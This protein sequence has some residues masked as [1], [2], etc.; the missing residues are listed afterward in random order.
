MRMIARFLAAALVAA[1]IGGSACAVPIRLKAGSF[2]PPPK[3]QARQSVQTSGRAGHYVVQ[4]AGPIRD[5]WKL[6]AAALGVKLQDYIPDYAFVAKMTPQQASSLLD[7]DCVTWVGPLTSDHK[8]DARLRI[9]SRNRLDLM[10]RLATPESAA[11]VESWIRSRNGIVDQ[12]YR[13]SSTYLIASLPAK[14]LD[15]LSSLQ[16]V[17]W[18]EEWQKPKLANNVAQ[19][20]VGAPDLRLRS[21]LYGAGQIIAFADSGLDTGNLANLSADFSGRLVSAYSLR[22]ANDWS[23][24]MSH[25]THVMG[26]AVG[27]GQLSGSNPP[28]H[29]YTGS[30]AGVA[31][32]AGYVIQSIGDESAFVYP[33]LDLAQLFQ[34]AYDDGARIHSDSWGSPSAGQYTVYSRQVDDF[35][36]HHPDMVLVFPAGN[37]GRDGN[38]DGVTDLGSVY[39]P[40]TAK[41]C[42]TVGATESLRDTGRV[43][44]YGGQWGSDF[45]AA[46]IRDDYISNNASGMVGWS[47][48]GPCQDGRT[49]PD[50]CAPATN[51]VSAKSHAPGA[52]PDWW[53]NY[54]ANYVYWGGTSMSTPLVAGAAALVRE[55]YSTDWGVE[56]SAALVKATL[57]NGAY[58]ITPGQYGSPYQQEVPARPNNVEGWGRLNLAALDPPAPRVVEFIDETAGLETRETRQYDVTVLGGSS[59][60]R[61]TLVWSDPPG[62]PLASLQLVNDL[63]LKVV[64]PSNHTYLGN[65]YADHV[66]NVEGV[67]IAS[68]TPGL[69]KI[70]ITA[71]NVP[72]GPQP[73]ALVISGELPGTYIA[74]EVHT[75][76]GKP[77]AGAR[78][79]VVGPGVSK[80]VTTNGS[81]GY[82]VHVPSGNYT[83]TASKSSWTF[84]PPSANVVVG[85]SGQLGVDFTG[86]APT[87]SVSGTVTRAVGG[88]AGYALESEHPYNNGS[89]VT[90]TITGHPSATHIR[91]HFDELSL[92]PDMDFVFIEDP[93][94]TPIQVFT[95]SESDVWTDWVPGNQV[96]VHLVSD[97]AVND[98]GF[99]IDGYETDLITQGAM[100][101]VTVTAGPG[102]G[103]AVTGQS[104]SYSISGL[105]PV[106]YTV[107]PDLPA[108]TFAPSSRSLS[109]PPGDAVSADFYAFPPGSVSGAVRT[110]VVSEHVYPLQSPNPYPNNATLEYTIADSP[111]ASR[112]RVH[113]DWIAVEPWSDF[114]LVTDMNNVPINTYTAYLNDVWSSWV[115]GD[116]LKVILISDYSYSDEGFSVD[117]YAAVT[118]EHGVPGVTVTASPGGATATTGPDGTYTLP[119]LKAGRYGLSVSKSYW[120]FEPQLQYVNAVAGLTTDN[121]DFFADPLDVQ[122]IGYLRTLPD[123]DE[124]RVSSKVVTAG[125]DQMS[126]FFYIEDANRASGIRVVTPESVAEGN[127]VDVVGVMNTVDGER[128]IDAS[129]VTVVAASGDVP[130][131]LGMVARAVSGGDLNSYTPGVELGRGLNNIG[132]LVRAVGRVEVR[133]GSSFYLDDGSSVIT[134]TGPGYELMKPL[135]ICPPGSALPSDGELVV[136]TGISSCCLDGGKSISAIRLRKVSD[137]APVSP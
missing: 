95:G 97:E 62:S 114:V 101:G 91:V 85:S 113:F 134:Q 55:H 92:E 122:A 45:P 136:V 77:V 47:G 76:T 51:I 111:G 26:C 40:G 9:S 23:D 110:G 12:D 82:S 17:V 18:V 128:C 100:E 37:D 99:Y 104:G 61:I 107:R 30:F 27:S 121:I 96:R 7:L 36:W 64:D 112:I 87:G 74:G 33:P 131:P 5:D 86:T 126:G 106:A 38:A 88:M 78:L 94:G 41:N 54:D 3:T 13:S 42:I 103:S 137:L 84:D 49:K 125:T 57:L 72:V 120:S 32:E 135:V 15:A 98:F 81:G 117:R 20:I 115:E 59:P 28:A 65:G 123:G 79:S 21:S 56:P 11:A 89:D 60:L 2:E 129:S 19:Q 71:T 130:L 83:V 102:G 75:A 118:D 68:P 39:A 63:D 29:S 14:A 6:A 31:P 116:S 70:T 25:G 46:P 44:T 34:P 119:E 43:V 22:R 50:I 16:D 48:R 105:E 10:V 1:L 90:Y 4:F 66:N 109:V 52:H 132:L 127:V 108:W 58:D 73:F 8:T 24:L 67:D 35:V 133:D 93:Q 53:A 69:Y 80:T 124:V